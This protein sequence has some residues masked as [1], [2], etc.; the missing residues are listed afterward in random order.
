[1][2]LF[3]VLTLGRTEYDWVNYDS[4]FIEYVPYPS[5]FQHSFLFQF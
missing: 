4:K 3:Q 1:M 2:Q 5:F